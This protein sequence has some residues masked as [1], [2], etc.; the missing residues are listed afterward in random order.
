M[1]IEIDLDG[2]A[3][4]F[5]R[6]HLRPPCVTVSSDSPKPVRG[7]LY[8]GHVHLCAYATPP[9]LYFP[10]ITSL[11]LFRCAFHYTTNDAVNST[12]VTMLRDALQTRLINIF[13]A[14]CHWVAWVLI[15]ARLEN[16]RERRGKKNSNGTME[17]IRIGGEIVCA[18]KSRK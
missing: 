8:S 7:K 17:G 18:D 15:F 5:R 16:N 12:R 2:R 10:R 13:V 6:G 9:I 4:R 1:K 11:A 14:S 3:A